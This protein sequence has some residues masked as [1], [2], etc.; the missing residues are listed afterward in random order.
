MPKITNI[1]ENFEAV[2]LDILGMSCVNCASSIKT[3]LEKV[4][5]VYHVD[6]NFTSE[7]AGIEYNPNVISINNIISDIRKMGY[8]VLEDEDEEKLEQ[9]KKRQIKLYKQ[10]I[11]ISVTLSLFI[12]A[13]S[14]SHHSN[15]LY[16]LI[17]YTLS[18]VILFFL[19]SFVVFWCGEK[20][21]KGAVQ[22]MK[23]KTSDMNTLITVGVFSSYIYSVVI[24]INH[25]FNLNIYAL[26][27]THEVYFETAAMIISFILIGNYLELVLKAKT[28]TSIKKLKDLHAMAK[29][30]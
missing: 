26:R 23:N 11:Y 15:L 8:D 19:T 22:A 28:Q 24:S 10:K 9:Q 14:M 13:I 6:I 12:M 7:V 3:Y 17:P 27:N 30:V 18:L 1:P 29:A 16:D 25:I 4:N 2:E 20:F 5:G 21:Y